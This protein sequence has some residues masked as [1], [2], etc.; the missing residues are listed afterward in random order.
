MGVVFVGML[1]VAAHTSAIRILAAER[2]A[3]DESAHILVTCDE[4]VASRTTG[5]VTLHDALA[6]AAAD[7]RDN[8]ITFDAETCRGDRATVKLSEPLAMN[9]AAGGHDRID[10]RVGTE[11]VTLDLSSCPDAGIVVSSQAH[12]TLTGLA[13][14]GGTQRTILAKDHARLLLEEVTLHGSQG[15]GLALFANAAATLH[16]CLITANATHGV[17]L[18]DN[19]AATLADS[20]LAG[21][22]QSGLA[23]FH[24]STAQLDGCTLRGNAQWN[25]VLTHGGRVSLTA[26]RLEG[27]G[28]ASADASQA[29]FLAMADCTVTAGQRFGLFLTGQA[30]A[31]LVGTQLRQHAGRG[32]ELQDQAIARLQ[33][34]RIEASGDYGAILFGRSQLTADQTAFTYNGAHGASLR[35]QSAGEFQACVF[36]GN[37]YSGIGCL[38]AGAGGRMSA[39][40]CLFHQNGMRPIYRGPL[41][42]DPLVPTPVRIQDT[43]VHCLAAPDAQIDMYLDRVGEAAR[44]LRTI[45]ADRHGRFIVDCREVPDGWVMTAAATV[46]GSTS[47]INVIAGSPAPALLA[48]LLGQTGPLSDDGGPVR[49]DA[50]PR[51]WPAGTH[52]LFH[53]P[54]APDTAVNRYADFFIPQ[55]KEWTGGGLSAEAQTTAISA[56]AADTVVIPVRYLPAE[57]P[58]LQGRG[59][60]TFMKW[61]AEGRFVRPME[62]V[63]A[64]ALDPAETCPRVFA[65]EVGHTLGLCHVRAGLLSRMQGSVPPDDPAMVNDFSPMFTFYDVQALHILHSRHARPGATLADLADRG[66]VPVLPSLQLAGTSTSPPQ[67]TFS[68]PAPHLQRPDRPHSSVNVRP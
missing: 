49:L 11:H 16:R 48:A 23:A 42:L 4:H 14:V 32:I 35:D 56:A 58:P 30:R 6:R 25:L 27:G 3:G 18:H 21:N 47:E 28:F 60:V 8:L 34:S 29:A 10:G 59:G 44:F 61:T 38:D 36:A 17:E 46:R 54:T 31:E 64:V 55:V 39:R 13:V 63:L 2:P 9:R 5:R 7:P 20:H 15:P 43:R 19:T 52:L 62:I 40:E 51:R 37:R 22:G 57:A 33:R 41:H 12:L 26:C 50:R 45:S 53:V 66:L 65:H 68:P 67:P 1:A 24:A